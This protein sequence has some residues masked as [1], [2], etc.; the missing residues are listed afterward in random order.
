MTN[1]TGTL[2]NW[3]ESTLWQNIEDIVHPEG[4]EIRALLS[5]WMHKI[6]TILSQASTSPLDFTLHDSQHAYRVAQRIV[7]IMPTNVGE[8]LSLYEVTLLLFSAYLHDIGM[9]PKQVRITHHYQYLLTG[10]SD[11]LSDEDKEEFDRWLYDWNSEIVVPICSETPSR[12][13]LHIANL[14]IMHYC[15][16]KHV[17]WGNDWIQN[18]LSSEQLGSYVHWS[19]DLAL[20]CASHHQ[21]YQDLIGDCFDPKIVG[22]TPTVVHLRYLAVLLRIADII[23]FDPERTPDVLFNHRQIDPGSEI[24]WHKDHYINYLL[25]NNR[26]TISAEPPDAR[27]HR[28]IDLLINDIETELRLARRIDDEL[29]FE[30]S[31]FQ[32]A[33]LYHQW[34]IL[35]DIRKD[36]RPKNNAYEYI[37]GAFRPDTQKLLQLLSGKQLYGQELTSIRELLSNAFDAVTE[38]ISLERLEQPN[39]SDPKLESTLGNLHEVELAIEERDERLW[40]VCTDDGVGMSKQIIKDHL[41]VSGANQRYEIKKLEQRCKEAGFQ[42]FRTGMFGI[43]V[44]SYFMLADRVEIKTKRSSLTID[45]ESNGWYFETEG[46][47]SFGELRRDMSKHRG[48]EV[49]IRL[50]KNIADDINTWIEQMKDFLSK[51]LCWVCCRFT[52]RDKVVGG[53]SQTY[54]PGWLKNAE[55]MAIFDYTKFKPEEIRYKSKT[56]ILPQHLK[57][58]LSEYDTITK[59]L[60][61]EVKASIKWQVEEGVLPEE[62]G[63][64]RIQLPYF[65]TNKGVSPFFLRFKDKN[66]NIIIS[67]IGKYHAYKPVGRIQMSW[68]GMIVT[69]PERESLHEWHAVIEV[70]WNDRA[71][72]T[73]SINR[74]EFSLSDKGR[75]MI[76]W[77]QNRRNEMYNAFYT[78]NVD[79]PFAS[80][81]LALSQSSGYPDSEL[82]WLVGDSFES[83]AQI[84]T[85]IH[86]PATSLKSLER[87]ITTRKADLKWKDQG[88]QLLPLFRWT[89]G[90]NKWELSWK[91]GLP[92]DRIALYTNKRVLRVTGL[93]TSMPCRKPNIYLGGIILDFPT[94]WE[95]V[96][97]LSIY[98]PA[99][100]WS[101]KDQVVW[102]KSH[103][104]AEAGEATELGLETQ[105]ELNPC[106]YLKDFTNNRKEAIIWLASVVLRCDSEFFQGLIEEHKE[107]LQKVWNLVYPSSSLTKEYQTKLYFFEQSQEKDGVHI[108]SPDSYRFETDRDALSDILKKPSK[109][110]CLE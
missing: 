40:L 44:L 25:E 98:S 27:I 1:R 94:E 46:V 4:D 24:F 83:G 39:P 52:F 82:C 7:E 35:P 87:I 58:K 86:F 100:N 2:H 23:E 110:W 107:L 68:Q 84:W 41:L 72:G 16:S 55:E 106:K 50:R 5:K 89:E 76:K 9:C 70:I 79:S 57:A 108:I 77:L 78:E 92:P 74:N 20:L 42:L 61:E 88:V 102:N 97:G 103:P 37:D 31:R 28:A 51:T 14:A 22:A 18:E 36:L 99:D 13:V 19:H 53:N 73:L 91:N 48:T 26:L 17:T 59:E 80:L 45:S 75:E 63:R 8:N 93:W 85:P 64:Y 3:N 104:I 47:G 43:G 56:D 6:Q 29:P 66:R 54:L 101:Y 67:M 65:T 71:V 90:W 12:E 60:D 30:N 11:M 21:G 109:E 69:W 33:P 49:S 95:H 62:L 38:Q 15:R 34:T 81:G 10:S 96:A 105:S 32:E